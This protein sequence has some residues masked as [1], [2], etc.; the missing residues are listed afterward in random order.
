MTELSRTCPTTYDPRL[1]AAV[2]T[3]N[4]GDTRYYQDACE[5]VA[6]ALELGCGAGRLSAVLAAEV[7][8]YVGLDTHSGLLSLAQETL[9]RL[10]SPP[11]WR[12]A[13]L[14]A[15]MTQL[16]L[17]GR[18]ERIVLPYS[19]LY[20]LP[21][22]AAMRACFEGVAQLL[23][24]DGEFILDAYNPDAFHAECLPEDQDDTHEDLVATVQV[25][26]VTY[27]VHES[28]RWDRDACRLW[29][30]YRHVD[31][32]SGREVLGSIEH[33]YLLSDDLLAE[34][35]RAGMRVVDIRGDFE[36]SMWREQGDHTLVHAML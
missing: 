5:G 35:E 19:G 31:K 13:L 17:T 3:G 20:C 33:H 15:D 22:L 16:P 9:D 32:E 1:Y 27:D 21:D 8:L 25:Q 26:G 4:P 29:T 11:D 14:R 10:P 6:S 7:P 2:H 12:R 23:S 34:L 28:S 30:T 36:G 18:F 24:P